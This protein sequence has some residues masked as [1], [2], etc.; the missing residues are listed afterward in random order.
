[1]RKPIMIAV[2]VLAV[3]VLTAGSVLA[4][5]KG[6]D[7]PFKGSGSGTTAVTVVASDFTSTSSGKVNSTHLGNGT[8]TIAATQTW[9]PDTSNLCAG[10]SIIASDTGTAILTAANGATVTGFVAGTTCEL[11]P[12]D[13]TT[14]GTTLTLTITGGT[15]RFLG[16]TGSIAVRGTSTGP[17][18]GPFGDTITMTGTISY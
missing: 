14:Y 15:G 12:F 18:G 9:G 16:A 3:M 11:A 8:Y 13:N 4:G 2:A 5:A 1:M 6:T 10:S 7:R 17:V